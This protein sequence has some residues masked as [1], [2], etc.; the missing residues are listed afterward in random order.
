[1]K[2]AGP[3][4]TK[5]NPEYTVLIDQDHL[6]TKLYG[7]VN[8]PTG[9]WINEQGKIVRPGEVAFIDDRYKSFSHLESAPYVNAIRDWIEKGERSQ[10]IMSEAEMKTRLSP[11]SPDRLLADAEFSLA[12]YMYRAGNSESA[13]PH[14]KE[15]QRLAP[16]N[17]NYKRQ[18]YLLSSNPERD[19][20][21]TFAKEVQ[22]LGD[23]PYYPAPSIPGTVTTPAPATKK[24]G[25]N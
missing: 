1:V 8:V 10:F 23:K 25:G 22:A 21:T 18:A 13:I 16:D 20:G 24:P 19:Y 3:W 5:A 14:F 17:W 4:I 7:L 6:V 11:E 9:V 15:A 12:E 2:D